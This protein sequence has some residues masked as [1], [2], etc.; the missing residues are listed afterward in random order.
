MW[1]SAGLSNNTANSAQFQL[2]L[3]LS[4]ARLYL[5]SQQGSDVYYYA[6]CLEENILVTSNQTAFG[7]HLLWEYTTLMIVNK[8][9]FEGLAASYNL[10]HNGPLCQDDGRIFLEAKRLRGLCFCLWCL[11]SNMLKLAEGWFLYSLLEMSQRYGVSGPL[12]H[13]I[14]VSIHFRLPIL[15]RKFSAR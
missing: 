6:D 14:D 1:L 15:H 12:S 11:P 10:T 2:G 7:L 4:L 5:L 8:C 13:D 3:R 9:S